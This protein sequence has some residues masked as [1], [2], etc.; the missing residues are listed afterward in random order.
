MWATAKSKLDMVVALDRG[1]KFASQGRNQAHSMWGNE[2]VYDQ[3]V[4]VLLLAKARERRKDRDSAEQLQRNAD[5]I[6][7]AR[8]GQT[9]RILALLKAGADIDTLFQG[10]SPLV[11]AAFWGH[12]QVVKIL[13]DAGA[14]V[15]FLDSKGFNAL[16]WAQE[17]GHRSVVDLL[18]EYASSE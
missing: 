11:W 18:D 12:P 17:R 16:M 1:V 9:E 10:K 15:N 2:W 13:L 7:A 5:L 8:S 14:D 3:I 4:S 6:Q